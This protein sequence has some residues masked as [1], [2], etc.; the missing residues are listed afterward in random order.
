MTKVVKIPRKYKNLREGDLLR[1]PS[2]KVL[3][4]SLRYKR[5]VSFTILTETKM[6]FTE[7]SFKTFVMSIRRETRGKWNIR[8]K[9]EYDGKTNWWHGIYSPSKRAGKF[10]RESGRY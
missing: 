6:Y 4:N 9:F 3:F 1:G 10:I 5:K 2:E 8:F 7:Y